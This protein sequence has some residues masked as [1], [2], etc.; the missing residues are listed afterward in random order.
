MYC[1]TILKHQY[2]KIIR[3]T[4]TRNYPK[5]HLIEL[6][7]FLP[8]FSV[9]QFLSFAHTLNVFEIYIFL[10]MHYFQHIYFT[11]LKKCTQMNSFNQHPVCLYLYNFFS[12]C[13]LNQIH[14][15]QWESIYLPVP[16][17]RSSTISPKNLERKTE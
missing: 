7:Q 14:L 5:G 1:I 13:P 9:Q 8:Q 12:N 11:L 2:C 17:S 16:Q 4:V 3:V 15:Y 6:L 10:L